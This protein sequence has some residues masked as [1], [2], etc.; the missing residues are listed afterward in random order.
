[1]DSEGLEHGENMSEVEKM[2][3]EKAILQIA[4]ENSYRVLT[5][6]VTFEDLMD[7]PTAAET[8]FGYS[9]LMAYDPTAG[10]KAHELENMI[11][12]YVE[13]EEYE[14]CGAL[15]KIMDEKYPVTE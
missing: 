3:I 1:M 2:K 11:E 4:Y 7:R 6:E 5:K 10:P 13:E 8:D 14:R 9:A 12:Y 15:K